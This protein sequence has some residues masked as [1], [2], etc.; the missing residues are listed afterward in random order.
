MTTKLTSDGVQLLYSVKTSY[1]KSAKILNMFSM[2][3]LGT[4]MILATGACK[5]GAAPESKTEHSFEKVQTNDVI[6]NFNIYA[7]N[8]HSHTKITNSHGAHLTKGPTGPYLYTDANGISHSQNSTLKPNWQNFQDYPDV[9]FARAKTNGYDFYAVTDHSQEEELN[10][11]TSP[12]PNNTAW[13]NTH[14]QGEAATDAGFVGLVGYEHS[15]ND[16]PGG[17]GHINVFNSDE[18]Q[19]ALKSGASIQTFYNWLETTPAYN[20]GTIVVASFNHPGSTGIDN[21]GH[22]TSVLTDRIT[23]LEVINSN[24]D[25]YYDGFVNALDAGWKVSPVCGNDNH[26]LSGITTQKSRTFIVAPSLS[27]YSLLFAMKNRRTYASLE[28]NIQCKYSVN[29]KI[30]GSTLPTT[31]SYS[32]NIQISDPDTGISADKIT[33]IDIIK[34]NGVIAQTYTVPTPSYSV[35]WTPTINDSSSK[36]F[37][38]RVWNAGGG[39]ASGADASKPVAWLAPV[40]T[41]R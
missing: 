34:S 21:W 15:E 33:K 17:Q 25:I 36:Y 9:H 31:T 6:D 18:Y 2:L 35:T 38:I 29:G 4:V 30:M 40:W 32:F 24:E 16:G 8:T 28:N 5:K 14:N 3:S 10:V 12:S 11:P 22:R 26:G 39:D 41:G 20:S 37:F 19:N 23:M 7:G 13:I 27:K 1:Q